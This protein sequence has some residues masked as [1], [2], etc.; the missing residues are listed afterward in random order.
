M[1]RYIAR[2]LY[3]TIAL[4]AYSCARIL[5]ARNTNGYVQCVNV[6]VY[7]VLPEVKR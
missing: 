2:R 1:H 6:V 7:V 5:D 3:V 4:Y